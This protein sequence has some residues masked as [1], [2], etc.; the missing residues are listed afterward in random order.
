[1]G[2]GEEYTLMKLLRLAPKDCSDAAIEVRSCL[3]KLNMTLVLGESHVKQDM[4]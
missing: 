3:K 1:M 4:D 2:R